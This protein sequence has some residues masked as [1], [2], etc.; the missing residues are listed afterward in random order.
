[1]I[2]NW[3]IVLLEKGAFNNGIGLVHLEPNEVMETGYTVNIE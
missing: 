3:I 2:R 1:M